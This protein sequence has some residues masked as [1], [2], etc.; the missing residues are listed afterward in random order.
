MARTPSGRGRVTRVRV[1]GSGADR[2]TAQVATAPS[3]GP[4]PSA[5]RPQAVEHAAEQARRD[6]D[7]ERPPRRR[8]ERVGPDA[9][10]LAER[11]E[12]GLVAAE[13]D[14]LGLDARAAGRID[15]AELPDADPGHGRAHDEPRD[16]DHPAG[17]ARRGTA[18]SRR[19]R[20]RPTSSTSRRTSSHDAPPPPP[21]PAP[22]AAPRAGSTG[23]R[24]RDRRRCRRRSRDAPRNRRRRARARRRP[25]T[26]RRGRPGRS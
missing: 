1:S 24:R 12:H 5:G 8:D 17:L 4:R 3:T 10:E 22:G 2:S 25:R 20:A 15:P 13:A 9:R 21:P 19:D 6:V 14:D 11:H 23:A 26:A 16:L 18:R 7:R